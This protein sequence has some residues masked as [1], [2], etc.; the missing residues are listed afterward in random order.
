MVA[1]LS[2][3]PARRRLTSLIKANALTNMPLLTSKGRYGSCV[4]LCDPLVTRA[5]SE[6]FREKH[7]KALYKFTF[8]MQM[9]IKAISE[10]KAKLV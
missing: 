2:T 4:K 10:K 9:H 5:I 3:N 6:H 8:Y 1:H 7:Y